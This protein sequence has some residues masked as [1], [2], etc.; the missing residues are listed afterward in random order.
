[1]HQFRQ[2]LKNKDEIFAI[3]SKLLSEIGHLSE[4][5]K[6]FLEQKTGI[7]NIVLDEQKFDDA[8]AYFLNKAELSFSR[9]D[10]EYTAKVQ[11][12]DFEIRRV[13]SAKTAI[14]YDNFTKNELELVLTGDTNEDKKFVEQLV[15]RFSEEE[16]AHFDAV[17]GKDTYP[18][19][20]IRI[21]SNGVYCSDR[22]FTWLLFGFTPKTLGLLRPTE[23]QKLSTIFHFDES[24]LRF[25]DIEDLMRMELKQTFSLLKEHGHDRE[26]E[27]DSNDMDNFVFFVEKDD[28][29][30][31]VYRSQNHIFLVARNTKTDVIKAWNSMQVNTDWFESLYDSTHEND[32]GE[33]VFNVVDYLQD[34]TLAD[35]RDT[36]DYGFEIHNEQYR[37]SV[38]KIMANFETETARLIYDSS[39]GFYT[40]MSRYFESLA[41]E[42]G[43][44]NEVVT[45]QYDAEQEILVLTDMDINSPDYYIRKM[46][47]G[48]F[49]SKNRS[50]VLSFL[51]MVCGNGHYWNGKTFSDGETTFKDYEKNTKE[52]DTSPLE[53]SISFSLDSDS[54]ILNLPDNMSEAWRKACFEMIVYLKEWI[55]NNPEDEEC[56]NHKEKLDILYAEYFDPTVI[57]LM[58]D[59]RTGGKINPDLF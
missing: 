47:S 38:E 18:A 15:Q 57:Y 37:Q 36:Y 24:V 8:F 19:P 41:N 35:F 45:D 51:F 26:N 3:I 50:Q 27:I 23:C 5:D 54:L 58:N 10:G 39:V 59:N 25:K 44:Q 33:M 16:L 22:E 43:Y 6:L 4:E 11:G 53:K 2:P 29:Q 12:M 32:S 20:I 42:I 52:R 28:I 17:D 40:S 1:M 21:D 14:I 31:V 46:T 30:G 7:T 49:C 55:K 56:Q 34:F 9:P 13:K 48:D